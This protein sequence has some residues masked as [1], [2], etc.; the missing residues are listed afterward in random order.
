MKLHNFVPP[1]VDERENSLVRI[2]LPLLSKSRPLFSLSLSPPSHLK[3]ERRSHV[4]R[5]TL[6][7]PSTCVQRRLKSIYVIR[8]IRRTRLSNTKNMGAGARISPETR[9]ESRSRNPSC[10]ETQMDRLR[11]RLCEPYACAA[12]PEPQTNRYIR[13]IIS[14]LII[15]PPIFQRCPCKL[16]AEPI[17]ENACRKNEKTCLS[18]FVGYVRGSLLECYYAAPTWSWRS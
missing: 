7:L 10:L 16:T 18:P 5:F 13:P 4:T 11:E 17:V 6:Q 3:R 12:V 15:P 14:D 9:G 8:D 1:N 2:F